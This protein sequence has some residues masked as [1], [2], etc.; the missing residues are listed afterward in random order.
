MLTEND[1]IIAYISILTYY[2]ALQSG[3]IVPQR[4]YLAG[5]VR[6]FGRSAILRSE[7]Y[8]RVSFRVSSGDCSARICLG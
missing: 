8:G 6:F 2:K 4:G 7:T 1:G 3:Q 5:V